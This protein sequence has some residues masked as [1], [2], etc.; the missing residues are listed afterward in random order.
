MCLYCRLRA[1]RAG[2]TSTSSSVEAGK[3]STD[4]S[5]MSAA[6]KRKLLK[7]MRERG[8]TVFG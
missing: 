1:K 3:P 4:G 7:Q 2:N 6:D 8:K 5:A